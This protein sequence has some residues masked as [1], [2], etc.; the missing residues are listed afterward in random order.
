MFE[1]ILKRSF[2]NDKDIV[3]ISLY[4]GVKF[5]RKLRKAMQLEFLRLQGS[6][7]VLPGSLQAKCVPSLTSTGAQPTTESIRDFVRSDNGH[8][9]VFEVNCF[10]F[11][12]KIVLISFCFIASFLDDRKHFVKNSPIMRETQKGAGAVAAWQEEREKALEVSFIDH[13]Y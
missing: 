11:I 6:G 7:E 10:L 8:R 3:K 4:E 1:A 2:V 12:I 5:E 13:C 9:I